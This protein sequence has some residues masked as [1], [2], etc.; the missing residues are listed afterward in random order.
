[1]LEFWFKT[2]QNFVHLCTHADRIFQTVSRIV[3][4]MKRSRSSVELSQRA[5]TQIFADS[6]CPSGFDAPRLFF[7]P[8]N[9]SRV[10]WTCLFSLLGSSMSAWVASCPGNCGRLRLKGKKIEF[11]NK[12]WNCIMTLLTRSHRQG[13]ALNNWVLSPFQFTNWNKT[14]TSL[15]LST[16]A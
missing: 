16:G 9:E 4:C 13:P 12:L 7:K 2:L 5:H 11:M 10:H 3:V 8:W 14:G 1:M 15:K 6:F